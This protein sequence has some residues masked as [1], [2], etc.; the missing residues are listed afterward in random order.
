MIRLASPDITQE[1]INR[2]VGVLKSG[3][4]VEGESVALF[5]GKLSDFTAIDHC[6][7]TSSATAGLHLMLMS[8]NVGHGETV[9]VPSFTFPA[10][11]NTVEK[12]GAEV[13]FCDV[14][15]KSYVAEAQALEIVIENNSDKNIK[16]IVIVH[17]FGY[18]ADIAEIK[19][20]ADRYGLFLIEDAAC[21]FGSLINGFSAGHFSDGAVFSFH[22]R[23]AITSGEGGAVVTKNEA[24]INKIRVLK[25]HGMLRDDS[26]VDF[27]E[28]G[29][30]Y[31]LTDFQA[32]LMIGQLERFS[33]ELNKRKKLV[34]HYY[35]QLTGANGFSLPLNHD[36]HSWQ[37]F[38]IVL[39]DD[40]CRRIVIEK[41]LDKGIQTNLGA[42]SLPCLTYYKN[43]YNL[44]KAE[45]ANSVVLYEKGLVLPL[46][47]KLSKKDIRY[48]SDSLLEVISS[49]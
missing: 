27:V 23:K 6:V 9:I 10:T 47:G 30:N 24:I 25:N 21:A 22:P 39:D 14:D 42:Q 35:E 5:Q 4:L 45:F 29:L 1:D 26:G 37:S 33:G 31:R 44:N 19:K 34:S 46:Y 11:A 36:G 40:T 8:L 16:G 41:L 43:K 38:M 28:A 12:T 20:V 32:A 2:V 15:K 13:L 17:E 48:I 7:L 49:I 3:N 18:P